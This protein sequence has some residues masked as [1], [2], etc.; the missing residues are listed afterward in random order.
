MIGVGVGLH[1]SCG[2]RGSVGRVSVLGTLGCVRVGGVGPGPGYGRVGWCYVGVCCV[3]DRSR[4]MYIVP[5]GY[6]RIL[7]ASSV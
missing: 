5:G 6:L 2:N 3:D 1:E 7:G 4:Y